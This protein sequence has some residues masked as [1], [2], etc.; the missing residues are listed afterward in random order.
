MAQLS[1]HP[2]VKHFQQQRA[3]GAQLLAPQLLDATSLRQLCLDA[4]ADRRAGRTNFRGR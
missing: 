4:G 3:D 2:T 1:E